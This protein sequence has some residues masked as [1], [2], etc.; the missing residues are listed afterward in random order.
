MSTNHWTNVHSLI[1]MQHEIIL[2]MLL[3]P[4]YVEYL[5]GYRARKMVGH[6]DEKIDPRSK[7]KH[8]HPAFEA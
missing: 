5:F 4:I 3:R 1:V 6:K 7:A 2:D 8:D